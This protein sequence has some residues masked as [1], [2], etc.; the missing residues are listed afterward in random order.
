MI[1]T[2]VLCGWRTWPHAVKIIHMPTH[3]HTHTLLSSDPGCEA[4]C[5][6]TGCTHVMSWRALLRAVYGLACHCNP[7]LEKWMTSSE[8]LNG[9]TWR[10]LLPAAVSLLVRL[11]LA[12]STWC[13][14]LPHFFF[15]SHSLLLCFLIQWRGSAGGFCRR[16][17]FLYIVVL[18]L[19][20]LSQYHSFLSVA[21]CLFKATYTFPE[22]YP[23][24]WV[25]PTWVFFLCL[26]LPVFHFLLSSPPP[27]PDALL[28]GMKRRAVGRC[29]NLSRAV[30][31]VCP[32]C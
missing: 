3:T 5:L 24:L 9:S 4:V 12:G 2:S 21:V 6:A 10:E 16:W 22:M 27:S 17:S 18:L 8:M 26:F 32:Q 23:G 7:D 31:Q 1:N 15:S 11:T 28:A 30:R 14:F 29:G 19:P 25:K 20:S 13:C